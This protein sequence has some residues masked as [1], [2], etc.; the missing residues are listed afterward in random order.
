M[1]VGLYTFPVVALLISCGTVVQ[2]VRERDFP[3]LGHVSSVSV[4]DKDGKGP[5]VKI[6]DQQKISE[7]VAF[8]D[9]HRKGWETTWYGIPVPAVTA[10]FY[11]GTELKGSFGAGRDFF[12][13][14]RSGIFCSQ[15]ASA[16]DVRHFLDLLGVD[17]I[18]AP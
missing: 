4:V 18:P 6:T 15:Q 3:A 1:K 16:N 10:E 13:T 9:S 7:I 8:V 11:T 5:L 12:E 17:R 2:H 14:Q